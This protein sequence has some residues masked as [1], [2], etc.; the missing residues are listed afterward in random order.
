MNPNSTIWTFKH[1][2]THLHGSI[3]F[4]PKNRQLLVQSWIKPIHS[5]VFTW[6]HAVVQYF[7]MHVSLN[8]HLLARFLTILVCKN[9]A[10]ISVH[11]KHRWHSV[12]HAQ[13]PTNL[14]DREVP[15]CFCTRCK[16]HSTIIVLRVEMIKGHGLQGWELEPVKAN[17]NHNIFLHEICYNTLHSYDRGEPA[18]GY[19]WAGW[20]WEIAGWSSRL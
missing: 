2:Q 8:I 10:K 5:H 6:M 12:S 9:Y 15:C 16:K 4:I 19:R 20:V 3:L 1:K 11:I 13:K 14:I 18:V 7:S 17:Y